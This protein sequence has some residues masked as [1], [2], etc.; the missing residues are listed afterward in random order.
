VLEYY[1]VKIGKKERKRM[2][3]AHMPYPWVDICIIVMQRLRQPISKKMAYPWIG[4]SLE[5]LRN[6]HT[7]TSLIHVFLLKL[8]YAKFGPAEAVEAGPRSDSG[9][10]VFLHRGIGYTWYMQRRYA[11]HFR[12]YIAHRSDIDFSLP[13]QLS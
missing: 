3:G 7:R 4:R 9:E 1:R 10:K 6:G 12:S 8:E 5:N 11:Q 13:I 2:E